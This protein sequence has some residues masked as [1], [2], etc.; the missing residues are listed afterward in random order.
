MANTTASPR[1][2]NRNF[3]GPSR[4]TT[5]VNTQLIAS[6]ETIVG[7]AMPAEPC[8]AAAARLMPSPRKRWVFSIVT[9]ESSTRMPTASASPPSV[10]VLS[11]SPRKCRTMIEAR[12]DRGIEISTISVD[13][14]DPRN[15]RIISPVRPA[16][17]APSRSTLAIDALTSFDLIDQLVDSQPGRCGLARDLKRL[18]NPVDNGKRRG[19]AVL[20]DTQEDRA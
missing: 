10:M 20:D 15:S 9:V 14:Q 6:V 16:A 2:V 13:R 5:E 12:I 7:T 18:A 17:I 3:A 8:S 4:N 1:G 11:V 19:V